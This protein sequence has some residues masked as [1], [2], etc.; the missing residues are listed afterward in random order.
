MRFPNEDTER[1]IN[2]ILN[3]PRLLFSDNLDNVQAFLNI[4]SDL[5]GLNNMLKV[6]TEAEWYEGCVLIKK[7]IDEQVNNRD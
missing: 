7:K 1:L 4:H 6:F 3:N 5:N 2:E